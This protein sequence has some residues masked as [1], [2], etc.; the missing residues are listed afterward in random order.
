MASLF[1]DFQKRLHKDFKDLRKPVENFGE[2]GNQKKPEN[3][4]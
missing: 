1:S 4:L 2:T 3:R